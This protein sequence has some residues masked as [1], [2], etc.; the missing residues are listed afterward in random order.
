MS[1]KAIFVHIQEGSNWGSWQHFHSVSASSTVLIGKDG[2]IWRLVPES[3]APWTNGDVKSP[4]PKG[5]NLINRF[6]ADPNRYALTIEMEGFSGHDVPKAQMDSL[7]WQVRDWQSR[8]GLGNDDVYRHADVNQITRP[9]CPGDALFNQLMSSLNNGVPV[10]SPTP[11]PSGYAKPQVPVV[12]GKSWDGTN[13]VTLNDVVFHADKRSVTTSGV[14]N[15]RQWASSEST[16]TGAA[17]AMNTKVNVLGWCIGESVSGEN[18][19]W[20][21]ANGDRLWVGGTSDKPNAKQ[22]EPSG[23]SL[24]VNGITF[25][26]LKGKYRLSAATNVRQWASTDSKIIKTLPTGSIIEPAFEVVGESVSGNNKW[27]VPDEK[28]I[29]SGGRIWAGT[30]TKI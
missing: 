9:R 8:Y 23:T 3:Q 4:T 11:Q 10:P 13:N 2:E 18:R 30:A 27:F 17:Y 12:G 14:L 22:P 15:R 16:L 26:P 21:G 20:I 25:K 19:W 28:S 1:P 24:V 29:K 5:W 6:G 7:I